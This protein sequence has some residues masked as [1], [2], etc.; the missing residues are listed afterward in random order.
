MQG[1][2]GRARSIATPH[3]CGHNTGINKKDLIARF[4]GSAQCRRA[5]SEARVAQHA[6]EACI[7]GSTDIGSDKQDVDDGDRQVSSFYV[8]E[9]TCSTLV[10]TISSSRSVISRYILLRSTALLPRRI[11]S[12]SS[13][14][15]CPWSFGC[16]DASHFSISRNLATSDARA[17]VCAHSIHSCSYLLSAC[18]APAFPS[19]TPSF[20]FR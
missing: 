1:R 3:M 18:C 11:V 20:F 10:L 17:C 19:S 4:S 13:A 12:S 2:T 7:A 8:R 16:F 6:W 14:H 9:M 15:S 5:A